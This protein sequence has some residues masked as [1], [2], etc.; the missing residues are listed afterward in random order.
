MYLTTSWYRPRQWMSSS[1]SADR[2]RS[3]AAIHPYR[4]RTLSQTKFIDHS[5]KEEFK[6]Y[7]SCSLET[8]FSHQPNVYGLG[9]PGH[10]KKLNDF[11]SQ[12]LWT[13]L[14]TAITRVRAHFLTA[15]SLT[16]EDICF[17]AT[18]SLIVHKQSYLAGCF[19]SCTVFRKWYSKN[20]R[21]ARFRNTGPDAPKWLVLSSRTVSA[22]HMSWSV[23]ERGKTPCYSVTL[24]RRN[25]DT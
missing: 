10:F 7:H 17:T 8:L 13:R 14:A 16:I 25:C 15:N 5:R 9:F 20:S 23:P 1:L 19:L 21:L 11:A 18:P 4:Q 2:Q 24:P 22:A 3:A 12:D 6:T